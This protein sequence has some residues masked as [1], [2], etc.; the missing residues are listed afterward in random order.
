MISYNIK[1]YWI[2]ITKNYDY[3]NFKVGSD[4]ICINDFIIHYASN[5]R[6]GEVV[7]IISISEQDMFVS[8]MNF[9][10]NGFKEQGITYRGTLKFEPK[11]QYQCNHDWIQRFILLS[12][13]K[14]ITRENKLKKILE[15]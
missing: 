14:I 2:D 7:K 15:L 8:N 6:F 5:V 12:D 1:K 9:Y 10:P 3:S 4:I 11:Y 13:W